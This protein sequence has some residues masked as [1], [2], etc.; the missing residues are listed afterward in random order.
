MSIYRGAGGA[1]DAVNDSSSEAV[2]VQQ[3]ANEAQADADAAQASATAAASSASTASTQATN[4][5]NSATAA[6][7][8]ASSASSSASTATTQATNASNSATAAQTAETNAETA[9]TNAE[10]AETNAETAAS[11]ASTSATNASN[12]ASAA[13]TSA[14]NA[15]NSATAAATSATNASNSASAASTSASNAST[16]ATSASGSASSATTSA[17]NAST[18]A[19]NAA[20][21]ATSASTSATTATTQAGIATTK[22]G[23]AATSATNASNS[24]SSASTSATNSASSAT[25]SASSAT[26]SAAARDAALAALDSF[27]DRYLGQ[28]STAPTLDNDG[29]ALVAGTLYFNTTTNEM[30]VYDGSAWL[31]A[32]ASLS[33][34]LLS[35]NN[36]SDL[37]NTAT[38]RTNLGVAI[39]TNVQAYDAELAAI[40]GLTSA[41]NK[42]PY[43]TGSG[44]AAVADLTVFGRSL[45]DDAD[46]TAA[47]TTLGVA[48]G[49]NVQ[50][51]D[52][53]LATIA[54]LTPTNQY[55]IIGNGT[56]W[57]SAAL[58]SSGVT[59]VTGTSPVA[60]SGGTTPAISLSTN[61]GD[62][63][64]PYASKTANFV[65]AAPN[66]S[67]GA[68][69]FRAVVAADI[70][71]LNQ[72]TTGSAATL[73]TSRTIAI[74]GDLAYTSPSFNGSTNVTAAG[75]LAT[76][77]ANVGSF[78]NAS[79][80]VNGKGLVTAVSSGTAPVTSV[81]GTAPVVSSG[82][83]TPAISMAAATTS[84]NGYLTSTDWNTFN[85]K[86][87][88]GGALG[89]PSSG[90]L[91]NCTFPTL[92]QNT[93]GTAANVT[94]T[95]AISNGGTG[96]TTAVNA[97]NALSPLTTL[98]DILYEE[99]GAV[100]AR[101]P[102][103][104]TGQVL[105]VS[106]G[107]PAWATA[108]GS[109][110]PAG[111]S[112]QT[113]TS[114]GYFDL[115]AGTTAQRPGTPATGMIRYNTSNSQYEVYNGS[116]WQALLTETAGQY[117]ADYLIVAGG[118][119]GGYNKSGG[120]GAGGFRTGTSSLT[121]GTAYTITVGGGGAGGTSGVAGTNGT[122]SSAFT[123][124]STG[125]GGGG[126][127]IGSSGGVSNGKAGG[128]GGGGSGGDA[129]PAGTAGS[130][131]AGQGNNGGAGSYNASAGSGGGGGGAGAAG[132]AGASPNG[133]AGG[134]GSISIISGTVVTYAGGGGG[135]SFQT[136][137]TG[138]T[139]GAGGG[140]NGATS[141]GTATPGTANTGGGGGG[142]HTTGTATGG[143]GVVIISY[144]GAQRGT[145]G[146]V[147]SANGRTIHTFTSSGTYT[148]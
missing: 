104:T 9:E 44:T 30:K 107:K 89:T 12:S 148:A 68:P 73:T 40:A 11:Q 14:T 82:G 135:A 52:A 60:S 19:T 50:A 4:A 38:A 110:T 101:L 81:T 102:I 42:L 2:L 56:S 113:N 36:L 126:T 144:I 121:L 27:D 103:G 35:T 99:T 134:S 108:S 118:G 63:Q 123:I 145:G 143:S 120:G 75:T 69:T 137:G 33:G 122:D 49:T 65:L 62:T 8:S 87:S 37:N 29:N 80:T 94:G 71:T 74:T 22:A 3:L 119:G 51:Y 13:S 132:T 48:I 24:A 39:G 53:D 28:K 47:R 128:S 7:S 18:S 146:T 1:G 23:E 114:T 57:T 97:F 98:G 85:G 111:V 92:N 147:T 106:G 125:G 84:V 54:G 90:T 78:T 95:V 133:G 41:A 86:Y 93:T 64:N 6:A 46:A 117:T 105:T 138:G 10:T 32:Y 59:S 15:S 124:S 142:A 34:A 26:A 70:P 83:T 5:S 109:A 72:N 131:T 136:S 91:T 100:A 115:P 88:V 16:S 58:P 45:I 67:A 112:D 139:G 130:G 116:I 20:N 21:S 96:Q 25:S 79:V 61:Y 129:N 77:N 31:N 66:G 140:G 43:F 55:A 127:Y 141:G 76:V 17:S